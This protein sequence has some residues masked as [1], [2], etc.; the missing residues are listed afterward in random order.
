MITPKHCPG[1]E[2]F[3]NMKS[4]TCKCSECGE[5]VEIFSDE[6]DKTHGILHLCIKVVNTF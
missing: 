5:S 1:F 3:K 6:F 2:A 4:F